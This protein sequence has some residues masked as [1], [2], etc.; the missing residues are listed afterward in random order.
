VAYAI[1][2]NVTM[3]SFDFSFQN[4]FLKLFEFTVIKVTYKY[5]YLVEVGLRAQNAI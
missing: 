4:W 1:G 3:S 2:P 5:L